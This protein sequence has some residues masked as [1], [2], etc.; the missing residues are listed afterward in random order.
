MAQIALASPSI[1]YPA[2]LLFLLLPFSAALAASMLLHHGIAFAGMYFLVREPGWRKESATTAALIYA[3]NGYMFCLVMNFTLVVAAAWLPWCFYALLKLFRGEG[4]F[5]AL[6][7]AS[8]AFLILAGR[9]EIFATGLALCALVVLI[10]FFAQLKET[11]K[12]PLQFLLLSGLSILAGILLA[13][14]L[15]M[16]TI[17]WLQLSA[18]NAMGASH[19]FA[20]SANWYDFMS[21]FSMQAFGN[22][23]R[24]ENKML[25]LLQPH[26]GYLPFLGSAFVGPAV[27]SLS[28][29]GFLDRKWNWRW[30][31]L[32][33]ITGVAIFAA[34]NNTFIAPALVQIIT[35]LKLVRYPIKLLCLLVFALALASARG[36]EYWLS[37]EKLD[38]AAN[39]IPL[40]FW[41]SIFL[42][43]ALALS[44]PQS[45]SFV[46][47][48]FEPYLHD[49][50]TD[51]LKQIASAGLIASILGILCQATILLKTKLLSDSAACGLLL[52]QMLIALLYVAGMN[53]DEAPA[54][55]YSAKSYA[56]DQISRLAEKHGLEKSVIPLCELPLKLPDA[57]KNAPGEMMV[58]LALY[59]RQVLEQN[60]Y[61]D[62]GIRSLLTYEGMD[63]V[64]LAL[65]SDAILGRCSL[66]GHKSNVSDEPLSIVCRM[67]GTSFALTQEKNIQ[68]L[69]PNYFDLLSN[70]EFLNV[71]IYGVKNCLPRLYLTQNWKLKNDRMQII[72]EILN[73]D[74]S[75]FDPSKAALVHKSLSTRD[76]ELLQPG[77][78]QLEAN[79]SIT[80]IGKYMASNDHIGVKLSAKQNSLLVLNDTFYPGWKAYVDDKAV[81]I[82]RVNALSRGVFLRAGTHTIEFFYRPDSLNYGLAACLLGIL[83]VIGTTAVTVGRTAVAKELSSTRQ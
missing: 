78:P 59:V 28:L 66:Y 68:K 77:S 21:M 10:M 55:F 52:T 63:T 58:K 32:A 67:T 8:I 44:A 6:L 13:A 15:I 48:G 18:R 82:F 16:P 45:L 80:P 12:A 37:S 71:R 3:L 36:V 65:L 43:S 9:P 50:A 5:I 33:A 20:W 19:Q 26:P 61:M 29:I 76:E 2:N 60:S 72:Q 1:F 53:K 22:P 30:W 57:Y 81:R 34:G 83:I 79:S 17:E 38:K 62:F 23:F 11:K 54:Q 46:I 56:A 35:P 31:L 47:A 41:G 14:P 27:L 24:F 40:Y 70:Q 73:S 42:I 64:D 4:R 74:K 51:A 7:S 49:N 69:D 39:W 25:P 75:G